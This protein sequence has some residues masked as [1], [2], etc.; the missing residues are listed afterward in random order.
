MTLSWFVDV[1]V[2]NRL[3][4]NLALQLIDNGAVGMVIK[5]TQG[6]TIVDGNVDENVAVAESVNMPYVLYHWADP[7]KDSAGQARHFAEVSRR[8][9][10]VA[11]CSDLEQY[12]RSWEEWREV[13]VYHHT[14]VTISKFDSDQIYRRYRDY[15]SILKRETPG[16]IHM[17]YSAKWFIHGYCRK[18]ATLIQ[19]EYD[20][21]WLASYVQWHQLDA[22]PSVTW[23]EFHKTI[24]KYQSIPDFVLPAGIAK[25]HAWQFAI[26]PIKGYGELDCNLMDQEA[27][28]KVFGA[29]IVPPP[30][31]PP[32]PTPM[33][34]VFEVIALD[35]L[36]IRSSPSVTTTNKIGC[37]LMGDRVSAV[38]VAGAN[39]WAEIEPGKYI[40][41]QK[42][43]TRFVK[44]V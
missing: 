27:A 36:T 7:T 11:L 16:M 23:G 14:D 44:S 17:A 10:P 41:V 37:L 42:G 15:T 4:R 31:P 28:K 12:W 38:D 40:C 5:A 35:G 29:T 26:M 22:D 32:P 20:Y 13:Y 9:H 8:F 19:E 3:D 24:D 43:S 39:A 25:A 18:L 34:L 33:P 2:W 1:S 30:P 21:S 6:D